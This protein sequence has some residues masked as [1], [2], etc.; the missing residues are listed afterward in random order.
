MRHVALAF[1]FLLTVVTL[2]GCPC[3]AYEGAGDRIYQRNQSELL[4][5]CNNGGFVAQ[6]A[7]RQIEG[8]YLDR[9]DGT[10]VT[11]TNGEDGQLAFEAT[12][13]ADA[14]VSAP[15]LGD[16]PWTQMNLDKTALDH[17][18]VLCQDLELRSW[19]TAQ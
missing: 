17:A 3:G 6:L 12:F 2:T 1:I 19:W 14:T 15:E 18:D 7:D 4:I 16:A 13:N 10:G 8:R 9:G 5:L 11:A